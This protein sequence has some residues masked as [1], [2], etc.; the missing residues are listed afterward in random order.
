MEI[1]ITEAVDSAALEAVVDETQ[2]FP[3][4]VLRDLLANHFEQIDRSAIWLT[5]VLEDKVVGFCYAVPE[6]L[7]DGTWNM[8]AI[9]VLPA[10]QG[11]GVGAGI[12]KKLESYLREQSQ[13]ILIA[14]TSGTEHFAQTRKFY[15]KLGYGETARIRDFWGH[16][17]DKVI[18]WK[19]L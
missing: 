12:V 10:R 5:A 8:L 16:G 19:A 17:D 14:D 2:L 9:A 7:T 3:P 15:K 11:Q 18:F 4:E 1:R 6:K 13:R